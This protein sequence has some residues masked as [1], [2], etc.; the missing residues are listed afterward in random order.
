MDATLPRQ[1]RQGVQVVA[2]TTLAVKNKKIALAAHGPALNIFVR[3]CS[4]INNT[5]TL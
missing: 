3:E 4:T 2:K 1:P 5:L